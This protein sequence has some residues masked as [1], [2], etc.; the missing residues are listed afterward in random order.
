MSRMPAIIGGATTAPTAV[1]ALIIPMAVARSLNGNHSA[2]ARVAAGKPPPSPTPSKNRLAASMAKFSASPWLAQ[3]IDQNTIIRKNP[4]RVPRA[5]LS[6]PPACVHQRV[7]EQKRRLQVRELL[8][9]ERDIASNRMDRYRQSLP[10]Q[11][12][13][14]NRSTHENSD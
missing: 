8:V 11:I 5:S 3:A 13:D 9:G 1:P 6:L 12:T 4:R 10:V 14:R 7:C 2:T